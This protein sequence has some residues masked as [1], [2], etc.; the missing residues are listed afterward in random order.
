V[1]GTWS[2]WRQLSAHKKRAPCAAS[3]P[4]VARLSQKAVHVYVGISA[5]SI[6]FLLLNLLGLQVAFRA[7]QAL[8][9]QRGHSQFPIPIDFN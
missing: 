1:G 8:Q 4:L 3:L 2:R 6:I 9:I 5:F 7:I